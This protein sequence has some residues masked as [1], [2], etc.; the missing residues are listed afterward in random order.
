MASKALG[1]IH[2]V[3]S[4][5]SITSAGQLLNVDLPGELTDQ[6]QHM[7]RCGNYFK[8]VGIDMSLDTVGTVGGGQVTGLIRYYAPT[9]GRCAAFRGAFKAMAEMMKNQGISM[10]DNRQ[11]DFRVPLNDSSASVVFPNRATLDGVNGLALNH[12]AEPGA[13]VFGVHNRSV[14]PQ[15]TGTAGEQFQPGFD[16]LIQNSATGTDFVLNDTVQ[17]TGN[18]MFASEEYE[19]IPFMMSWTPDSTDIATSFQW[20][21]DPALYQA[22]LCGQLQIVIEEVNLDESATGLNLQTAFHVAGWK[23][24]MGNPDKKRRSRRSN[25]NGK[26]HGSKTSTT[27]TVTTV[28]K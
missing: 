4:T 14:Q 21:P 26:S 12:V 7:I 9:K 16:T 24:I 10:R 20:R 1:Q 6:L 13:S 22:I 15:Y 5:R 19:E 3:N 28:K 27:T 2:T 8:L 25:G 23:S 18:E 17:Y 11:Y